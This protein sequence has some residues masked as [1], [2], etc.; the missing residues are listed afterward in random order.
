MCWSISRSVWTDTVLGTC[1][2]V[3]SVLVAVTLTVSN[4]VFAGSVARASEGESSSKAI[5]G[6]RAKG[7]RIDI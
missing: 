5:Q 4:W 6:R 3:C 1:N 2:K 7:G